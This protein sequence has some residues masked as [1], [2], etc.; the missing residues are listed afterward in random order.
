M[1]ASATS[2]LPGG[3]ATQDRAA[4]PS[5][6]SPRR[7]NYFL[8][9]RGAAGI[10]RRWASHRE[11]MSAGRSLD[12]VGAEM[13]GARGGTR[14]S[15]RAPEG[16]RAA[17]H[18]SQDMTEKALDHTLIAAAKAGWRRAIGSR[19][20]RGRNLN[21]TSGSCRR[22]AGAMAC[23]PDGETMH[24]PS[25]RRAG[26]GASPRVGSDDHGGRR[27]RLCGQGA[28]RRAAWFC[29]ARRASRDPTA[30]SWSDKTVLY[31]AIAGRGVFRGR[32]RER[33]GANL[34]RRR[35]VE[36]L[37]ARM[38]ILTAEGGRAGDPAQLAA[39]MSGG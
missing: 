4:R 3:V 31:G 19:R 15:L 10:W 27:Q 34:R 13:E 12:M 22:G 18:G 16:Q 8:F 29:A 23:R 5:R 11:Q 9:V 39:G 1:M 21:S 7:S 25:R 35:V 2:T 33:S 17:G 20:I 32:R 38:R 37:G 14:E 24:S 36:G 28:R 30:T 6:A 26:F